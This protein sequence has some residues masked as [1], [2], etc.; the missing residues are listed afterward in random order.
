LSVRVCP[1]YSR[2]PILVSP[3]WDVLKLAGGVLK[4]A[5]D[6]LKLP[7]DV[8]KFP[9]DVAQTPERR[10]QTRLAR[11]QTPRGWRPRNRIYAHRRS[12]HGQA[13][14][15][16]VKESMGS[17]GWDEKI[18]TEAMNNL[19]RRSNKRARAASAGAAPAAEV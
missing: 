5:G 4:L 9:S 19:L 17:D 18:I 15:P 1:G 13:R 2:S 3:G 6:V 10:A 7:G 16:A 12:R 11:S 8:L 14:A